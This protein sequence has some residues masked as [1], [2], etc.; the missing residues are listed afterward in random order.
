MK[1]WNLILQRKEVKVCVF[2]N[3]N[4]YINSLNKCLLS[5]DIG[6]IQEANK[7]LFENIENVVIFGNGGS[8]A[9][10]EHFCCDFVKGIRSDTNLISRCISLS[11]N[12]PLVTAISNDLS[13]SSIFSEQISYYNPSLAIAVS[14]SGNSPNVINGLK[15][16]SQLGSK[17]LAFVGFDGGLILS[18][19]L[20]DVIVHVKIDNY[21]LV[22]DSHMA[23]LHS[24]IQ[25]IRL[26]NSKDGALLKL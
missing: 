3:F 12:G 19:C 20:A 6:V 11:S 15:R 18:E 14:S 21:G 17:T 5:I 9:I 4:F 24:L 7:L 23:I 16:A 8:A 10:A 26:C 22:E 1:E 2:D 13:Y 25:N